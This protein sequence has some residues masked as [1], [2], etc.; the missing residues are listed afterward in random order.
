MKTL[1]RF[2]VGLGAV[3]LPTATIAACSIALALTV[4]V[5]GS[6]N[7]REYRLQMDGLAAA[8]RDPAVADALVASE[9]ALM[10]VQWSG[11][12]RQ[13]VSVPWRRMSS[14]NDVEAFA[15][16]AE[17][18]P[19]AW[20]VFSTGIGSALQ[21]TAAQFGEVS[22][23]AHKVID[24]SGDGYS[25]EGPDPM[26]ISQ[27]LA[28]QGFQINGLAIEGDEFELTAYYKHNVVAG[29]AAFVFTAET[30]ADYPRTIWRK[31]LSE[32]IV[33]IS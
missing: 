13:E 3:L 26:E 27:G 28:L 2:I 10:L 21:F 19:R 20:A 25:N 17:R 1:V 23:C 32:L 8:L 5:S 22:D 29:E 24:V 33:P 31:L 11:A 7:E 14:H 18:A 4:D 15:D 6:I 9:V 30:Y 12:P 16:L